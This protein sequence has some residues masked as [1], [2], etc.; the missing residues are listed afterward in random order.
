MIQ[1]N[2]LNTKCKWLE[3]APLWRMLALYEIDH[4]DPE[5]DI[6]ACC[7]PNLFK[8]PQ[9][10]KSARSVRYVRAHAR[11]HT[12]THT[13]SNEAI[14][15]MFQ[16][17]V[18]VLKWRSQTHHTQCSYSHAHTQAAAHPAGPTVAVQ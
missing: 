12:H 16:Y 14:A 2:V 3:A 18:H 10:A 15:A 11:I 6:H 9:S 17:M 5:K 7:L 8:L 4:P 1:M 13:H